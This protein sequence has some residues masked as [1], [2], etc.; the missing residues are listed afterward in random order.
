VFLVVAF[1]C[2]NC[3]VCGVLSKPLELPKPIVDLQLQISE[4]DKTMGPQER[5]RFLSWLV[6]QVIE[7]YIE[8]KFRPNLNILS[9]ISL[10]NEQKPWN[11]F[12][13][14]IKIVHFMK[15]LEE[16]DTFQRIEPWISSS[17]NS[18]DLAVL[19]HLY[20]GQ[21]GIWVPYLRDK[22]KKL[23][24]ILFPGLSALFFR[25]RQIEIESLSIEV[26]QNQQ[27]Y[28]III[29][30][31]FKCSS[32]P[33]VMH[34]LGEFCYTNTVAY[35]IPVMRTENSYLLGFTGCHPV[36]SKQSTWFR[37]RSKNC[38]VLLSDELQ[39]DD[40]ISVGGFD[41]M[42]SLKGVAEHTADVLDRE[43]ARELDLPIIL[44]LDQRPIHH[45][46]SQRLFAEMALENEQDALL[47]DDL[48][49]TKL[50]K[51]KLCGLSGIEP[52]ALSDELQGLLQ[53]LL[54]SLP[55]NAIR[56]LFNF[57]K[58]EKLLSPHRRSRLMDNLREFVRKQCELRNSFMSASLFPREIT[59]PALHVIPLKSKQKAKPIIVHPFD[60][61]R[62]K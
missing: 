49:D 40:M 52:E 32:I 42:P 4:T 58:K 38:S 26:C 7:S 47:P 30:C 61:K 9:L 28:Q 16:D 43:Y 39:L 33:I 8:A 25:I 59:P 60:R 34:A 27:N 54:K 13:F 50:P 23:P 46:L 14:A 36:A 22:R 21:A 20:K 2:G 19:P 62:K 53:E 55:E 17:A 48:L 56:E 57:Y 37:S 44:Q 6:F 12:S 3:F 29:T 5:A 11:S 24:I 18:G 41:G 1:F 31:A 45:D 35:C 15:T 10:I 51:E